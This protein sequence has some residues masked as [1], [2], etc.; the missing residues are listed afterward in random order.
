MYE[1]HMGWGQEGYW[2]DDKDIRDM[3]TNGKFENTLPYPR[4]PFKP[5]IPPN[6]DPTQVRDYAD[7]L[8][9]YE[10]E[11][12]AYKIAIDNWRKVDAT[13]KD[14]FQR[15]ALEEV[16]LA[17]HPK[18]NEAYNK[19]KDSSGSLLELMDELDELAD[20]MLN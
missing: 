13:L 20:L 9:V 8:E 11:C 15:L 19:A 3:I 2:K 5:V 6:A 7:R 14:K 18:A 4:S 12:E 17:N 10:S 16:G 1:G